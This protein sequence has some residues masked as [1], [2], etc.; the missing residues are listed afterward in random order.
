VVVLVEALGH[1][2]DQQVGDETD[3]ETP[4]IVN[5]AGR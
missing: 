4:T 3:R 5:S 2:P 1:W